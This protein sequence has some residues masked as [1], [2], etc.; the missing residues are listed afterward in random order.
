MCEQDYENKKIGDYKTFI[1]FCK[2]LIQIFVLV[3]TGPNLLFMPHA[4]NKSIPNLNHTN[5]KP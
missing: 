5:V 4:L 2:R 1:F 3:R